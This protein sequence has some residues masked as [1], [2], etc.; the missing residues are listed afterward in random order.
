MKRAVRPKVPEEEQR[1]LEELHSAM[2]PDGSAESDAT[3]LA[4]ARAAARRWRQSSEIAAIC[5]RIAIWYWSGLTTSKIQACLE[6]G[7]NPVSPSALAARR[8]PWAAIE[9][10]LKRALSLDTRCGPAWEDLA[11]VYDIC[12]RHPL[13][14]AAA[15]KAVRYSRT[16]QDRDDS[17][18][19]LLSVLAE[20]GKRAEALR[21]LRRSRLRHTR[22]KWARSKLADI[23]ADLQ[24]PRCR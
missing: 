12:A 22:S 16:A 19:I 18:A 11:V 2:R 13:A 5:G 10:Q 9:R 1:V 3:A 6:K 17:T 24:A 15:R 14:V 7:E 21:V 23:R 4:K 8:V 20:S